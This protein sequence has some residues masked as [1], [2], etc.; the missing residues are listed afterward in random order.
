MNLS[1]LNGIGQ[2][3]VERFHYLFD[4]FLIELLIYDIIYYLNQAQLISK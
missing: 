4:P 2:N 3:M 1:A